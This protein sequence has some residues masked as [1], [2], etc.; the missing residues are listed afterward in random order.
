MWVGSRGAGVIMG[1]GS[2]ATPTRGC[3]VRHMCVIMHMRGA[4][5]HNG[6]A[7]V[8]VRDY[9]GPVFFFRVEGVSGIGPVVVRPVS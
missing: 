9:W 3:E 1:S 4:V 2:S 7:L 8:V 6:V 5:P